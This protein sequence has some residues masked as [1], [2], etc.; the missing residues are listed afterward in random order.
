MSVSPSASVEGDPSR[1]KQTF[2]PLGEM[3]VFE[4]TPLHKAMA[5]KWDTGQWFGTTTFTLKLQVVAFPDRSAHRQFTVVMPIAKVLPD[6]GTQLKLSIP[7][8]STQVP[9]NVTGIG[10]ALVMVTVWPHTEVDWIG[11]TTDTST[12]GGVVSATVT[13]KLQRLMLA[14]LSVAVQFTVFW[15]RGKLVPDGGTQVT[16]SGPSQASVALACQVAGRPHSTATPEGHVITGPSASLTSTCCTGEVT[17]TPS[18]RVAT[19][20]RA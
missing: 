20:V 16:G 12:V 11:L 10:V 7:Q 3:N 8:L 19:A 17:V 14:W 18:S 4:C 13:I 6:V 5:V 15:P 2:D 1:A 9:M